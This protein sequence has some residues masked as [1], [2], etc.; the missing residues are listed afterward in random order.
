[1]RDRRERGVC[2]ACVRSLLFW[3]PNNSIWWGH[4]WT[5]AAPA[6]PRTCQAWRSGAAR[7]WRGRG[8]VVKLRRM[9]A[10]A[11]HGRGEL[12]CWAWALLPCCIPGHPKPHATP[13]GG[14]APGSTCP[15][16]WGCGWRRAGR[17]RGAVAA[18]AAG[19]PLP[20]SRRAP[21]PGSPSPHQSRSA[22]R[23][24]RSRW[25]ACRSAPAVWAVAAMLTSRTARKE[26]ASEQHS[27]SQAP[28]L[29]ARPPGRSAPHCS[30]RPP[31]T[32]GAQGGA[33]PLA[34]PP[35]ALQPPGW[36]RRTR[37][38]RR[39]AARGRLGGQTRRT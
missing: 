37:R 26:A 7:R 33:G 25:S 10:A 6:A 24:T 31:G 3:P 17:W 19:F 29:P 28:S 8:S 16:R 35:P 32:G 12:S 23:R 39:S 4:S 11:S 22:A 36:P 9:A 27:V 2:D 13:P 5:P 38:R 34:V 20:R 18:P 15:E 21:T 14:T 1:M 30:G